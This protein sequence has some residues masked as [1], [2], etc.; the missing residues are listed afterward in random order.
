M[1][2]GIL[3]NPRED[4]DLRDRAAFYYR[5]MQN[6][7]NEFKDIFLRASSIKV[8]Q[9][10]EEEE[11]KQARDTLFFNTL[12]IIYSKSSDKFIKSLEHFNALK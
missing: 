1:L 9:F 5:A 2:R 8:E 12:S 6:D 11:E 3:G 10:I 7:I 4:V